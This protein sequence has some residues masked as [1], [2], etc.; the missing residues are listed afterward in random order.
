MRNESL[1]NTNLN[2]IN[3]VNSI[4]GELRKLGMQFVYL[5]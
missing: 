5:N 1:R 2:Y 3:N 4:R